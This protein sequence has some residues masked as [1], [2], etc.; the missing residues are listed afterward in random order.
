MCHWGWPRMKLTNWFAVAPLSPSE[1]SPQ[2]TSCA[3]L[4]NSSGQI[5]VTLM[6][7]FA[8]LSPLACRF[9][10]GRAVSLASVAIGWRPESGVNSACSK[11]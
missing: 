4:G 7:T 10:E 11:W 9:L 3:S 8:R 6:E 1:Q 5:V 2:F